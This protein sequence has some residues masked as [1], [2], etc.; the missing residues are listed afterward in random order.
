MCYNDYMMNDDILT[1]KP[2]S[3]EVVHI[4]L[5]VREI[6]EQKGFDAAKLSRKADLGYATVLGIWSGNTKRPS[7]FTLQR[8]AEALEVTVE[9]LVVKESGDETK[10][11]A[12]A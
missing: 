4:R 3:K 8:L 7:Y 1:T 11:Q 12:L 2:Y 9:D 6:A 5:R 10:I